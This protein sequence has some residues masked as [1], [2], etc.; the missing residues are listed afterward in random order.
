MEMVLIRFRSIRAK[1][2]DAANNVKTSLKGHSSY[3]IRSSSAQIARD[4]DGVS[5]YFRS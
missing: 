2:A 5:P 1:A 4:L 3:A